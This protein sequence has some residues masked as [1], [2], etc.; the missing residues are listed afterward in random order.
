MARK[1]ERK[2]GRKRGKRKKKKNRTIRVSGKDW[3][4]RENTSTP[5]VPQTREGTT[6][7]GQP[8]EKKKRKKRRTG[9]KENLQNRKGKALR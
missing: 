4:P 8:C 1:Q 9:G 7:H 5:E 2:R 3:K 6:R